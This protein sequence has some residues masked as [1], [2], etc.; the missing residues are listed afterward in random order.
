MG[1]IYIIGLTSG[2]LGSNNIGDN[3][4]FLIKFKN[5]GTK[6]WIKQIG[7]SKKDAGWG[8]ITDSLN[9]IYITGYTEGGLDNNTNLGAYDIFLSKYTLPFL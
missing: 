1:N 9:N 6:E 3:D 4:T 7:T 5:D 8:L 2:S